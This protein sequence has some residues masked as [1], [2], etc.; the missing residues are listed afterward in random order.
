MPKNT[1]IKNREQYINKVLREDKSFIGKNTPYG[2]YLASLKEL[3][4][5][6]N[7][8]FEKDGYMDKVSYENL[9]NQYMAVA[10]NSIDFRDS[11]ESQTRRNVV[12]HIFKLISR[13]IKALNS[14]DK[15]NPGNI[16]NAFESS[17]A[18]TVKVPQEMT[19]KVGGQASDRFPM[20]NAEGK[21]GFFT[22]RTDTAHD[23]DWNQLIDTIFST[24]NLTDEEKSV[25]NRLR[26]D[27]EFRSQIVEPIYEEYATGEPDIAK[28]AVTL[29]LFNDVPS[30]VEKMEKN[31]A[32]ADAVFHFVENCAKLLTPYNLQDRLGYDPY[33][34]NDNK[35]SAMY[36]VAKL[37]GCENL[38]AK[39]VPMV[40]V[41]GDRVIKGT[42]ME[43]AEGSDLAN[44]QSDDLILNIDPK[45]AM[46]NKN[47]YRDLADMQV[48][49]Y[50]C[51]NIDRHKQNMIYKTEKTDDGIVKIT[52][53][54]AIDNDAS[55]PER[56]LK[57][58]EFAFTPDNPP[59][60]YRPENFRY[61]NRKTANIILNLTREQLE[62]ALRG[63]NL[64]PKAIEKAWQR[65]QEVQAALLEMQKNNI[66]FVEDMEEKTYENSRDENN[67]F[68]DSYEDYEKASIFT[69]FNTQVNDLVQEQKAYLEQEQQKENEDKTAKA[70]QMDKATLLYSNFD[71]IEK[72]NILMKRVNVLKSPS[73]EF[74][75]MSNALF[76][77]HEYAQQLANQM[78]GENK[79]LTKEEYD[80]YEKR[81]VA[82][83]N[84]TENYIQKKGSTPK[85]KNG[86]ERH[87]AALK[88]FN[89]A[90]LLFDNFEAVK[91]ME[92]K[93][94]YR[95]LK[96]IKNEAKMYT[97]VKAVF[98]G[99][100][101]KEQNA[102]DLGDET[103]KV[104]I[105]NLLE[106][107]QILDK[108]SGKTMAADEEKVWYG[109]LEDNDNYFA[110]MSAETREAVKNA[111]AGANADI[112]RTKE[113]QALHMA[114]IA[115]ENIA[116]YKAVEEMNSTM[117]NLKNLK[118]AIN[119]AKIDI[120]KQMEEAKKDFPEVT[121][122]N[123]ADQY[124]EKEEQIK[125]LTERIKKAEN[126]LKIATENLEID[127]NAEIEKYKKEIET[128]NEKHNND[129]SIS[130][131]KEAELI[132][133]KKEIE[134]AN[135]NIDDKIKLRIGEINQ[136]LRMVK[137]E[138]RNKTQYH[139]RIIKQKESEHTEALDTIERKP[140][141]FESQIRRYKALITKYEK[142]KEV[143][144][145]FMN[146]SDNFD[147]SKLKAALENGKNAP[148]LDV[149]AV[150]KSTQ[151]AA[152]GLM[153]TTE[154]YS[155]GHSN[156][157]EFKAMVRDLSVV[158]NWGKENPVLDNMANPPKTVE[159]AFVN[160]K[161]SSKKY[162]EEKDK[163]WR[164][165]P[166]ERRYMRKQ[167]AENLSV[168]AE[169]SLE[170]LDA[171]TISEKVAAS[172]NKYFESGGKTRI[173]EEKDLS[174]DENQLA[175]T[176]KE[177]NEIG[178]EL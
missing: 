108:L 146:P 81:M 66:T 58:G 134:E 138:I 168:I 15:E 135:T 67:P 26:T 2:R 107:K 86:R 22:A 50:I 110:R 170:C 100:N 90:D 172:W 28:V 37:L 39:A 35:N 117:E 129:I 75:E 94:K 73:K 113:W 29:T 145:K 42:F 144:N 148:K 174:R 46:Y 55:F 130:K 126:N 159:Q 175:E 20:K 57:E 80:E 62:T 128:L 12:E 85:T 92:E 133:S 102:V 65:T 76:S 155:D 47:L 105:D 118:K 64:K 10:K 84:A 160:L 4:R 93:L 114:F 8:I 16:K 41:N 40:V 9:L 139:E 120:N 74:A 140:K 116:S 151:R 68:R 115:T 167:L 147:T 125:D 52:G 121:V 161:A 45:V 122:K 164:P 14:M 3:A 173:L 157:K 83:R 31:E 104:V 142:A 127:K 141:V 36:D 112:S 38:V 149:N 171:V 13:D 176:E 119:V 79:S 88:L 91:A 48:I 7:E 106:R 24:Y 136:E 1:G 132:Q 177:E 99:H 6:T 109:K 63:H 123:A 95:P 178:F 153:K 69:G 87:N 96:G 137:A 43:H 44:P 11:A 98:K 17:R 23:K 97:N 124:K 30:A 53:I 56:D 72:M 101:G 61:V 156:S 165:N 103:L 162:L 25:F 60:I 82:M 152:E 54:T 32:L 111:F 27:H 70:E 77:L 143:I 163:Q 78:K 49:D 34:R 33:T 21:K 18:V 51:G 19:H 158:M 5:Q 89:K 71:T 59:R 150:L 154:L 166:S 131:A 169:Q